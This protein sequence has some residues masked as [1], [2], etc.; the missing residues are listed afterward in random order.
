[1]SEISA[2]V[3]ILGLHQEKKVDGQVPFFVCELRIRLFEQVYAH[4]KVFGIEMFPLVRTV[5]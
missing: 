1:M 5:H 2:T 4:E 3:V